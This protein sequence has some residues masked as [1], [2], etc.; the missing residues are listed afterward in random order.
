MNFIEAIAAQSKDV[1]AVMPLD[2]FSY[3]LGKSQASPTKTITGV[4]PFT[5]KSNGD[6]LIDWSIK[7]S[8]DV[9]RNLFNAT[10]EQGSFNSST[11]EPASAATRVRSTFSDTPLPSGTYTIS[12][13]G[14]NN[15][16]LYVYDETKAYQ[17]NSS[18]YLWQNNPFTFE[19]SQPSYVRFAWK[20]DDT[21]RITP[22][23]IT[24]VMLNTGSSAEPY[25]PY[26]IGVGKR[27][28]NQ[29][30][31]TVETQ[32]EAG[33]T[34]TID[35]EAGTITASGKAF[36]NENTLKQYIPVSSSDRYLYFSGCPANSTGNLDWYIIV[37]DETARERCTMWDGTSSASQTQITN[38]NSGIS[39]SAECLIPAN[40]VCRMNFCFFN[41][42]E[43]YSD[44]VF[45]PMLREA[46]TSADFEPY[47]YKIPVTCGGTTTDIF[48]GDSPLGADDTVSKTSTG[49]DIPTVNG[50]NSLTV[51]TT[52]QPSEMSITYHR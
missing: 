5:F 45:Y 1:P 12:A 16:V 2:F 7:G 10:I 30:E 6:N 39:H 18:F 28:K 8:N 47:G 49:V 44:I 42:T 46:N 26:Q 41:T 11:G 51:D 38:R 15:V 3:L 50:R 52:V 21:T 32:T 37:W 35:K 20:I 40:H 33:I 19:V 24:D 48:I 14:V 31:L 17:K 22:A 36:S 43:T 27:T 23:D 13:S 29:L 9:G 4:P 34:W 25:E